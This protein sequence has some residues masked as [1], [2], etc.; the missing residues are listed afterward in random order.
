MMNKILILGMIFLVL[1][2]I[3]LNV[4]SGR[5][6]WWGCGEEFDFWSECIGVSNV[7]CM[8]NGTVDPWESADCNEDCNNCNCIIDYDTNCCAPYFATYPLGLWEGLSTDNTDNSRCYNKV[9]PVPDCYRYLYSTKLD[10]GFYCNKPPT[11]GRNDCCISGVCLAATGKC[12]ESASHTQGGSCDACGHWTCD[13]GYWVCDDPGAT[14]Y[15]KLGT[16]TTPSFNVSTGNV[17][18]IS[19]NLAITASSP[20]TN[21]SITNYY[22]STNNISWNSTPLSGIINSNYIFS[23][24]KPFGK[25]FKISFSLSTADQSQTPILSGITLVTTPRLKSVTQGL[26]LAECGPMSIL[27]ECTFPF[28]AFYLNQTLGRFEQKGITVICDSLGQNVTVVRAR[29]NGTTTY[30]EINYTDNTNAANNSFVCS[31]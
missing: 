7:H 4:S 28:K 10:N 23:T 25:Y 5:P 16:Y 22:N 15:Y 20:T 24:T 13:T 11:A 9:G 17:S 8:S 30:T 31:T 27:Y 19:I 14:K 18:L 1:A 6:R 3:S 2:L 21:V 26:P 12:C 29:L